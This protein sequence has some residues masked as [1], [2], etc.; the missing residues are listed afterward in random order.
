MTQKEKLMRVHMYATRLKG[1]ASRLREDAR[2]Y[3][4]HFPISH[5]ESLEALADKLFEIK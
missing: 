3:D 4:C 2:E 5:A 1:I